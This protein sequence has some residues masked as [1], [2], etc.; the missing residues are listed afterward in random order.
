[1]SL[2]ASARIYLEKLTT[3]D[4]PFMLRLLNTAGWIKY[5]GDRQVRDLIA[6]E[7]YL[8][9]ILHNPA[10]NYWVIRLRSTGE[11]IGIVTFIYRDALPGPDLG[12]ALLE[13]HTGKGFGYEAARLLLQE[14]DVAGRGQTVCAVTTAKNT[15]SIALLVRL[16]FIWSRTIRLDGHDVELYQLAAGGRNP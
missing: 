3:G 9:R 8:D 13:E 16:G 7:E 6:A 10:I 1:M 11:P 15:P 12:F 4:A 2:N 5:I 14:L